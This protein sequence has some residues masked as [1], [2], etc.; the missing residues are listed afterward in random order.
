MFY[1]T[2]SNDW[3]CTSKYLVNNCSSDGVWCNTRRSPFKMFVYLL[4]TGCP[5]EFTYTEYQ[6]DHYTLHTESL[7]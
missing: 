2:T 1:H 4:L 7:L 3:Y 6:R 5:D